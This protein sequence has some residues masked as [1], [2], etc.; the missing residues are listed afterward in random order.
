MCFDLLYFMQPIA[1]LQSSLTTVDFCLIFICTLGYKQKSR[2]PV[3]N[4]Y[5][6]HNS[7]KLITA[8]I[9]ITAQVYKSKNY[10]YIYLNKTEINRICTQLCLQFKAI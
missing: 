2:V 7:Q 1:T 6:A 3:L 8:I 5:S 4:K 9:D 10:D